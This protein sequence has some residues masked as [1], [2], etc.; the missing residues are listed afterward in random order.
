MKYEKGQTVTVE[1]PVGDGEFEWVDGVIVCDKYLNEGFYE[2]APFGI[3]QKELTAYCALGI[4]VSEW[5][6][7]LESGETLLLSKSGLIPAEW[8]TP[9][10]YYTPVITE[11]EWALIAPRNEWYALIDSGQVPLWRRGLPYRGWLDCRHEQA[12][13]PQSLAWVGATNSS[14]L[15]LLD[16]NQS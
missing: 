15:A 9:T 12:N 10:D 7:F 16:A 11:D 2:V 3:N 14:A 8:I 6:L 1:I 13:S 5:D 4:Y